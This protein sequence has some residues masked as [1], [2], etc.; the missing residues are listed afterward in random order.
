MELLQL[1]YFC[2]AAE[3]ENFSETA[4]DYNVPASNISQSIHRLEREL[5]V[6][7]FDRSANRIVLNERGRIFYENVKSSLQLID[8]GKS[9]VCNLNTI[10]GEIRLLI[11][12]N[13]R[14]VSKAIE[15]FQENYKEVTFFIDHTASD[16]IN[17][18]DLIITDKLFGDKNMVSKPIV[19]EDIMLALSKNN[20]LAD[21]QNLCL[22]DLENERFITMNNKSG[23]YR[24]TNEI[25]NNA[26][27]VPNIVIQSDDPF[28]I[29]KYVEMGMGI[30]LFPSVSW[31]GMFSDDV[32]CRNIIDLKRTTYVYRNSRRYMSKAIEEFLSLLD[33]I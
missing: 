21:K 6:T 30:S 29:R 32:V 12:A 26:G 17:K 23:L 3:T 16:N 20:P 31:H 18:Y 2:R 25:C 11:E 13:R 7:L 33:D 1:K 19:V 28:Y 10:S 22:S 24:L 9:R 14:I 5:G 15:V 4:K 8:E 27:F